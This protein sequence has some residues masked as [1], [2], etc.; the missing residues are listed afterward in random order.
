MITLL[1]MLAFMLIP[2]WIPVFTV[3]IG[4]VSDAVRRDS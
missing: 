4:Y 1:G 2:I 3:A